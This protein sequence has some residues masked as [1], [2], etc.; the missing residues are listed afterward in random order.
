MK[1]QDVVTQFYNTIHEEERLRDKHGQIEFRT[2]MKYIHDFLKHGMRVLEIGAGTGRYSLALAEE[3]YEVDAVEL[4]EH[5]IEIFRSKMQGKNQVRIIQGNAVD[6]A[7]YQDETFDVT[8]SLGPMYHLFDEESKRRAL[9]EAIRVTKK[10]GIIF[11][12]Y[13]MNEATLIQYCF[14]KE[15]IWEDRRKGLLSEDF[16]WMANE[17][18]AFALMRSDEIKALTQG[19]PVER[20]GLI[21]SDGATRYMDD[22]VDAMSD[23]LFELYFRYHLSVCERQDLIGASNHSLDILRRV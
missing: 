19:Y 1:E 18:D 11:I 2:T 23:E 13:C 15:T 16:H 8:L 21:A 20:I 5:N 7:A 12:A 3:G 17:N 14:Q 22:M 10:N 6:L 9:E 4:V